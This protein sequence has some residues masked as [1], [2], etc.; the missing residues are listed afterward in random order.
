MI[1]RI[2]IEGTAEAVVDQGAAALAAQVIPAAIGKRLAPLDE[3]DAGHLHVRWVHVVHVGQAGGC[4]EGPGEHVHPSAA[5]LFLGAGPG[6]D[7]Q[8]LN[9]N[10]AAVEH[11]LQQLD[12]GTG[13]ALGIL[14]IHPEHWRVL[15]IASHHDALTDAASRQHAGGSQPRQQP[16]GRDHKPAPPLPLSPHYRSPGAVTARSIA[17]NQAATSPAPLWK[18]NSASSS[19]MACASTAANRAIRSSMDSSA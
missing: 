12:G 17:M 14:G 4:K 8:R 11:L 2:G 5:H 7:M 15:C 3:D 18:R 19:T 13:E 10:A 9:V 1:G 16:R 6:A